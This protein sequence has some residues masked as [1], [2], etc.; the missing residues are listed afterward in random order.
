MHACVYIY[1]TCPLQV[2]LNVVKAGCS[3]F[4]EIHICVTLSLVSNHENPATL[5]VCRHT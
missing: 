3:T 4:L 2:L 5:G 1:D